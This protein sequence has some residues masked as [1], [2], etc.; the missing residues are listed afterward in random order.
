MYKC[1]MYEI[2]K[3]L[4]VRSICIKSWWV[5]NYYWP[6]LGQM[7]ILKPIKVFVQTLIVNANLIFEI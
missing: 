5:N 1:L 7:C 2:I 3:V 4:I 6:S